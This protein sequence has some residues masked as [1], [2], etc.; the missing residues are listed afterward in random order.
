MTILQAVDTGTNLL[1]AVS[2]CFSRWNQ[3]ETKTQ[4]VLLKIGVNACGSPILSAV[5]ENTSGKN[6]R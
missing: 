1:L 6:N 4:I 3:I 5:G 2:Q